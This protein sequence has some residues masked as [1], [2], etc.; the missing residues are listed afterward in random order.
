MV[1]LLLSVLP[2]LLLLLLLLPLLVLVLVEMVDGRGEED[3]DKVNSETTANSEW[4]LS[5]M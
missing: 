5:S 2:S 4:S 3:V 1:E